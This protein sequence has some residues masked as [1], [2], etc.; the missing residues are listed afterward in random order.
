M[1]AMCMADLNIR[2]VDRSLL[3]G[4]KVA[5]AKANL[6]QRDFVISAL[7]K[8]CDGGVPEVLPLPVKE[9]KAVEVEQNCPFCETPLVEWGKQQRHCMSCR[10]NF[11]KE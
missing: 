10:R 6:T 9:S 2:N 7:V 3:I 4:V 5:A 8:A 1:L 11:S